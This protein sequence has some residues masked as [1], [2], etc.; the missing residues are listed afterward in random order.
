M[1]LIHSIIHWPYFGRM[2]SKDLLEKRKDLKLD[3]LVRVVFVGS[4][5]HNHLNILRK[6]ATGENS[7]CSNNHALPVV[8]ELH[9]EDIIFCLFPKTASA[10]EEEYGYWAEN[11]V[12]DVIEMIMQISEVSLVFF[13]S[14]IF[15]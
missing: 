5:G 1:L 8:A 4:E 15:G 9:F 10:V 12:G 7:V 6:I 13:F 2:H 14:A 3:V 11:P